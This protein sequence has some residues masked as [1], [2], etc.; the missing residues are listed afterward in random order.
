MCV[1]TQIT[2]ILVIVIAV[3]IARHDF[4]CAKIKIVD[5]AL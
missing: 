4:T 5:V 2:Q 3:A 1:W